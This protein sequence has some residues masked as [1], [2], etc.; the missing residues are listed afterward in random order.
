MKKSELKQLIKEVIDE[1]MPYTPRKRGPEEYSLAVP[2]NHAKKAF[3][4]LQKLSKDKKH[5][6][7]NPYLNDESFRVTGKDK[8]NWVDI[9][10]Q[11]M[12]PGGIDVEHVVNW[13]EKNGVPTQ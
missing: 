7:T 10:F 2:K 11:I 1:M 12:V 3:E 8:K 13:L 5:G 6:L 4:M 9:D